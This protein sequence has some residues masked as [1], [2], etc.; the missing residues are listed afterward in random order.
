M[1]TPTKSL[2]IPSPQLLLLA[3][4]LLYGVKTETATDDIERALSDISLAALI[5]GLC[6]DNAKKPFG[7]IYTMPGFKYLRFG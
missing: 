3:E 1:T 6:D 5:A 4:Q 7:S 2:L